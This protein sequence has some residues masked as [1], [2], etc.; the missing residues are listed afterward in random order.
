MAW[1]VRGNRR[2]FYRSARENGRVRRVYVGAGQ[3][4][5]AAAAFDALSR[6]VREEDRERSR[7]ARDAERGRLDA[8]APLRRLDALAGALAALTLAGAGYHR[9]HREAWRRRREPC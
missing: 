2:Y 9:P 8:L 3:V 6:A 4:A 1:Y 7:A 5:E